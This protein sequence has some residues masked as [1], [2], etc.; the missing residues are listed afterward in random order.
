[1]TKAMNTDQGDLNFVPS[2]AMNPGKTV[3]FG[4][5]KGQ[6][7]EVLAADPDYCDWL[8]QQSWFKERYAQIYQVV[9]INHFAE[10]EETPEHNALQALF[11]EEIYIQAFVCAHAKKDVIAEF[12]ARYDRTKTVHDQFQQEVGSVVRARIRMKQEQMEQTKEDGSPDARFFTEE[13]FKRWSYI[14]RNWND[15]VPLSIDEIL[16]KCLP[17]IT[18]EPGELVFCPS[19]FEDGSDVRFWFCWEEATILLWGSRSEE[20]NEILDDLR[21]DVPVLASRSQR[22]GNKNHEECLEVQLSRGL[23]GRAYRIEVKPTIGDDYPKVL[24]QIQAQQ[25]RE[26]PSERRTTRWFLFCGELTS[27]VVNREQLRTFFYQSGVHV[28][29]KD[30]VDP[31]VKKVTAS[32]ALS[33]PSSIGNK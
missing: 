2:K 20:L 27:R 30:E 8:A 23:E 4:K 18:F 1:M 6:P 33:L 28:L 3:P 31:W 14:R 9:V 17:R 11:L 7:V 12:W 19:K 10:P 16:A 26:D 24:R 29:Y 25:Q 13:S 22:K 32:K 5:Y 15:L 21:H